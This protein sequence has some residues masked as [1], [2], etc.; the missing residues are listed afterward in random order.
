MELLNSAHYFL[1][2]FNCNKVSILY[3]FFVCT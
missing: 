3:H 2:M 1:L